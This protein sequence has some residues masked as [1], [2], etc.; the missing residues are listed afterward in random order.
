MKTL[1]IVKI[2]GNVIDKPDSLRRFLTDFALI[3][4]A[5]ILVHGGGILASQLL[6][7]LEIPV[8]MHE[9]RRITD[10]ETLEICA[11]VYAGWINKTIV[12]QLQQTHCN[13]IG[14]SGADANII[15]A[16]RRSPLPFDYGH[17]GDVSPSGVSVSA[18]A[19][20]LQNDTAP[21]I[22]AITHD[23]QGGLLNTNADTIASTVAV[24]LSK[25][26]DTRLIYCF[27]K[28]G[29]LSAPDD[30]T[31]VISLITPSE[32]ESLK[33]AGIISKGMIPKL[34]NA[35]AACAAGVTKVHI[36]HADNLLSS[37][38]TVVQY[39]K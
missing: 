26:Y 12:A 4:G 18:L 32:F 36:K 25:M 7:K 39:E 22:C 6:K 21:V 35:F 27:E 16:I 31:S 28:Q 3:S 20:F 29:V 5:K 19:E 23:G 37:K 2:G 17:V 13:A 30:D 14:L 15:T 11:M 38:G 24:A 1:T 34:E 10:S 8:Q 33:T 9:G